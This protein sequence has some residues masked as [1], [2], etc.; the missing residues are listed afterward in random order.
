MEQSESKGR[1]HRGWLPIPDTRWKVETLENGKFV[2]LGE[3]F[4]SGKLIAK[5]MDD[6]RSIKGYEPYD[7]AK[8]IAREK[9]ADR[10][11]VKGRHLTKP[12][13]LTRIEE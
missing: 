2:T 13:I 4:V 9:F 6:H 10:L 8:S 7:I 3:I 5:E 11:K 12:I 1:Y